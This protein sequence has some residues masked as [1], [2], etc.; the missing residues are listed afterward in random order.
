FINETDEEIPEESRASMI[1]RP[2]TRMTDEE[3]GNYLMVMCKALTKDEIDKIKLQLP[4]TKEILLINSML[5]CSV[6]GEGR[7][8]GIFDYDDYNILI[9]KNFIAYEGLFVGSDTEEIERI[10]KLTKIY[11]QFME[12]KFGKFYTEQRKKDFRNWKKHVEEQKEEAVD[13]E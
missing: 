3:D 10:E 8:Y 4:H 1:K 6:L 13:G 11:R 5:A 7:Q 12:N 2:I 9:L